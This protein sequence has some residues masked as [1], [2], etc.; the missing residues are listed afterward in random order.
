MKIIELNIYGYGQLENLKLSIKDSLQ[1]FYGENEAGKSTIM[2]FIHGILFGFPTKQQN[3]LRYEP[4]L[5]SRYGGNIRV[6]HEQHGFAVIERV[7]G[8]AVGDVTVSMEN[9]EIGDEELLK[10]L[11]SSMDKGL[12]QAIFSF[13]LQ[14]LQNIHQMKNEEIGKFLFSAGTFGTEK[15]VLAEAEIKKELEQRFKPGGKNPALNM[16]LK[17]LNE[18][19]TELKKASSKTM[20][21]EALIN[22]GE[23]L[24]QEIANLK[25]EL[26]LVVR[27]S[28]HL[29]E[30][31]RIEP[32]TREEKLLAHELKQLGEV[33]F[34][35]NGIERFERLKQS[36]KPLFARGKILEERF[37]L[38][39]DQVKE[40]KPDLRLL[41]DEPNVSSSIE[42][43][44]LYDQLKLEDRQTQER[45]FEIKETL[46]GL[47]EKLHLSISEEELQ[48]INTNIYM[49][50]Q[51]E[52]LH[53]EQQRLQNAK[54][55]LD[56][57]FQEEKEKLE[58]LEEELRLASRKILSAD[59]RSELEEQLRSLADV[60]GLEDA[61]RSVQE[62]KEYYEDAA[63]KEKVTLK[64]QRKNLQI[65][66]TAYCVFIVLV[67]Y[68]AIIN[69]QWTFLTIAAAAAAGLG[70]SYYF[71]RQQKSEV[72]AGQ[73]LERLA[74]KRQDL[75]EK[76]RS[77]DTLKYSN[78]QEK[79]EVDQK[80]REQVKI[81][82]LK[83]EQQN[84]QYER[85][86]GQYEKWEESAAENS[87]NLRLISS[88]LKI[89]LNLAELYL[90]D[91]F[92]LIEQFKVNFREK[93]RLEEKRDTLGKEIDQLS[94]AVKNNG[95]K[96]LGLEDSDL[97]RIAIRLKEKMRTEL[98]KQIQYS[99]KTA[100]LAELKEEIQQTISEQI[101]LDNEMKQLLKT[102]H[103]ETED[104]FYLAGNKAKQI[105]SISQ[106]IKEIRMQLEGSFLSK[107]D[108]D[109]WLQ[110]NPG[111][112]RLFEL[113]NREEEAHSKVEKLLERQAEVKY[114]IQVLEDGG[115]YSELLH[116]YK[117]KRSE[118]EE[119][120]K[121]WAVYSIAQ[122]LLA[123]TVEKYKNSHLP[124]MLGKAEEYLL[125]LTDGRYRRIQLKPTGTG[126]LIERND[127]ILFEANELSQ[128]TAEQVYVS[129]RLALAITL[130]GDF[131]MPIII[132]DGFVNFDIHRTRK[133]IDLLKTMKGH[134][135]LFFTC[136]KHML[137]FFN[138]ESVI[139]LQEG[140]VLNI[141]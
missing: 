76:L 138:S 83:W 8:K 113:T 129:L 56:V 130:Y 3:E 105:E 15:L 28:S 79:L 87:R 52:N 12:Y 89:P 74:Q 82:Q 47:K 100:K 29:Q 49:K 46:E 94:I 101:L 59:S 139:S 109:Q 120:A 137:D 88:E 34:P 42:I 14:G 37:E 112:E 32:L 27:E 26:S 102:A 98:D 11:L 6:F 93:Q 23:S 36:L 69:K 70:F 38:L 45:L 33:S 20:Q 132:D 141:S 77:S 30:W 97:Q 22:E 136:H 21:Y 111:N 126:F 67:L 10:N 125:F 63:Q 84:A 65:Q 91:A 57:R 119:E 80:R 128:A 122:D 61:L 117:Q 62:Q 123:R 13:N 16:K 53:K 140:K 95:K 127:H 7:K 58:E 108:R 51:V 19:R 60:R 96:Y 2:A 78:L 9:G 72:P 25:E 114:E 81:L 90:M 55:D 106:R 134:Q 17:E 54:Q 5:H 86:I 75:E 50:K 99:E 104:Q 107:D 40:L 133:V 121:E 35:P 103:A 131:Q 124:R 43:M 18:L 116:R 24:Q 1:V 118:F 135:V 64:R 73:A 110:L 48:G 71:N 92:Q 44:P 68:Y 85:I 39:T 115:V 4:K 31:K 66:F 41:E